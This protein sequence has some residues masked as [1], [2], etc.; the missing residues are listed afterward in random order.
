MPATAV[1]SINMYGR[2]DTTPWGQ[3][4]AYCN[5]REV[6]DAAQQ[7]GQYAALVDRERDACM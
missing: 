4:L 1:R 3:T 5:Q 2:N 7:S 6:F